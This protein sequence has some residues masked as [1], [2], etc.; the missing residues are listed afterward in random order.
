MEKRRIYM[1]YAAT[2]PVKSEVLEAMMPYY[3]TYF[4]NASSF[5]QFGR[6]AKE[7]LDK[8]RAQVASLINADQKVYLIKTYTSIFLLIQNILQIILLIVTKNYYLYLILQVIF[9]L[10]TNIVIGKKAD[11]LYP[12]IYQNYK[13]ET[14]EKKNIFKNMRSMLLYKIG[15]VVMN[16]T[17]NILISM[18]VGTVYVGYYSNYSMI[19]S[20]ITN[21]IL[22]VITAVS[23][24]VGNLNA[25]KD[26]EKKYKIFN[27]LLMIFNW[28]TA[29]CAICCFAVI[30]N[31]IKIWVGENYLLDNNIVIVIILNFYL[32]NIINPVW[33]YRETLGLFNKIK[34]IMI[35]CAIINIGLSILLGQFLGIYGILLATLISKVI[36]I[37]WYEP[38]I[39]YSNIF[40]MNMKEYF[41]KQFKYIYL[42]AI[43]TIISIIL[44][45]FI[46]ENGIVTII[47]K[48]FICTIVVNAVFYLVC[49]KTEE[50]REL[51]NRIGKKLVKNRKDEGGI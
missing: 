37:V 10:L 21:I 45:G 49:K 2:T 23:P 29:F 39:L 14:K 15:A 38:K 47:I 16:N 31:F 30:N 43:A 46:K 27:M 13:L 1:D 6:E 19:I 42:F 33:M 17:D 35:I 40:K 3:T 48:L 8:G 44:C 18:I 12:F 36:T 24:S 34:Y 22:V 51:K 25:T 7:G 41:K 50:F 5:H 4:G 20:A 28:I 32:A 26:N 9:T 11:K